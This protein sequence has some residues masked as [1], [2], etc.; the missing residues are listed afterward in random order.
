MEP[1]VFK[2]Q[3]IGVRV[4][5]RLK[6]QS[7]RPSSSKPN[8]RDHTLFH[9]MLE[10]EADY[11]QVERQIIVKNRRKD[12]D[13]KSGD[14]IIDIAQSKGFEV[15]QHYKSSSDFSPSAFVVSKIPRRKFRPQS[16]KPKLRQHSP[17]RM[18]LSFYEHHT[19]SV[20]QKAPKRRHH[21]M[22]NSLLT[23][24]GLTDE[25]SRSMMREFGSKERQA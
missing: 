23:A 14:E 20:E 17:N 6:Q 24:Q 7:R 15:N 12:L 22:Y 13:T 1:N 4:P 10:P 5:K 25:L 2:S 18:K 3:D 9:M 19:H 11:A 21:P 16:S 8:K